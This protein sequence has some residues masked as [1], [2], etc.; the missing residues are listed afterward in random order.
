MRLLILGSIFTLLLNACTPGSKE[1]MT[2]ST[3]LADSSNVTLNDWE[4]I[5]GEKAG[6]VNSA[7]S[8]EGLLEALG[9]ANVSTHDTVYGAEGAFD[10]GTILYK[11]TPNEAH[12]VWR[13]TLNFKDPAYVEV[14]LQEPGNESKVQWYTNT[15]VKVGT[16]LTELEQIN[17]K[18]FSFSG[19]GWDYGG[20][21]VDWNGGK[22]MNKDSTSYLAIV[23]A[24][25]YENQALS[26]V[27][28][29]L[30][31]DSSFESKNPN[32]QK[33]NPFVSHFVISFK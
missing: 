21:V 33:L 30:L 14:G 29:K 26:P 20:A 27:A 5:A 7:S 10:I 24:Y 19:F 28:D 11:G 2:D 4:C 9:S 8:E 12:I 1:Q 3:A 22:L 31:G 25:D 16:K 17:G 32:A 15:G 6:I 23:L 13:D 18:S